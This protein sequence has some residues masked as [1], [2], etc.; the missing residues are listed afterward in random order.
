MKKSKRKH[1]AAEIMKRVGHFHRGKLFKDF[2]CSL[3]FLTLVVPPLSAS[4]IPTIRIIIV[5]DAAEAESILAE[6]NKGVPFALLAKERSVDRSRESYGEIAKSAFEQLDQPLKDAAFRLSEGRVSGVITLGDKRYALVLVVDMAYY[7]NGSRAFRSGDF[8]TAETNLLK[9]VEF[10]PDAVKARIMLGRI[11]ES[12]KEYDKAEA[13]YGDALRFNSHSEEAYDRLGAL[14]LHRGAL[15]EAKNVYDE[16]LLHVPG[17]RSLKE[18]GERAGKQFSR[19]DK[20]PPAE[21]T[22]TAERDR[23]GIPPPEGEIPSPPTSK[24]GLSK[25]AEDRRL[26]VRIIVTRSESDARDILLRLEKGESMA[27]LAKASSIDENTREAYGYLGEVAVSSLNAALRGP[28]LLLKEG[29]TSGVIRL[30]QARYAIAQV[31]NISLYREIG[32]P[33]RRNSSRMWSPTR[34][35]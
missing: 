1:P 2:A 30:E 8:R 5:K 35:R 31:T 34:T 28:L 6:I 32:R 29:Q 16:G 25:N 9:H 20:R 21:K 15:R 22:K 33:P 12:R 14:Y 18:G 26:H 11:Y 23:P 7:R 27:L 13:N 10:N 24:T 19:V 4:T 17:S 3:L